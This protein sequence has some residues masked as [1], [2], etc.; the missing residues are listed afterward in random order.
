MTEDGIY[1]VNIIDD[2]KQGRYLP[3]FIH[4]LRQTFRYV[5]LFNE[6]GSWDEAGLDTY[7]IAATARR[8]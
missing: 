7:I 1:M 8:I 5:Y 4:T 6:G 3:S 2:Y